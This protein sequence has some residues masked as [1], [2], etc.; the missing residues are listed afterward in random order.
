M[1]KLKSDIRQRCRASRL[2]MTDLACRDAD[3]A[4]TARL[5]DLV[6]DLRTST[7]CAFWP[8]ERNGEI[9]TRPFIRTMR[10][11]GIVVGLPCVSPTEPDAMLL[12]QFINEADLKKNR[13][14]AREPQSGRPIAPA[15]VDLVVVPALAVDRQGMR[16]GYGRG[17]YDRFLKHEHSHT[18]SI[19]YSSCLLDRIPAESHDV[20]V[21][22]V[23]T[24]LDT[25]VTVAPAT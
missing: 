22:Y 14:G 7:V 9:D 24:E 1:R 15:D 19:V 16:V 8:I 10:R 25:I 23:I 21:D 6:S 11:S 3:A 2:Q 17:Y 18:V 13:W 12:R 20:P 5:L 4:I